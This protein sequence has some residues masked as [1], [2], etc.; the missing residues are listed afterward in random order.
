VLPV[1]CDLRRFGRVEATV[2]QRLGLPPLALFNQ[3]WEYDK[4]PDTFFRALYRVQEEGLEFAV[5]LAGKSYRQSA[6]E[7]DTARR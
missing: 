1:G 7:L 6:P 3:R 2:P 5:A 4:D